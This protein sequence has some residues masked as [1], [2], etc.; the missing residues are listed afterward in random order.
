MINVASNML[1]RIFDDIDIE[2]IGP[3]EPN[4]IVNI[5]I[6]TLYIQVSHIETDLVCSDKR[7]LQ[8]DKKDFVLVL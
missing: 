3:K 2:I 6:R 8:A 4:F 1:F 5:R 7:F